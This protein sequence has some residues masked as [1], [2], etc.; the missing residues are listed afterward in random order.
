MSFAKNLARSVVFVASVAA[1]GGTLRGEMKA[2]PSGDV[3]FIDLLAD[4]EQY[5]VTV[6]SD[7]CF[8]STEE[9]LVFQ[10]EGAVVTLEWTDR[11]GQRRRR[12]LT[13]AALEE[14]RRFE[15]GL[16]GAHEG[17][18]TT[19]DTY[20]VRFRGEVVTTKDASCGWNGARALTT[21]LFPG[22]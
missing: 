10:R 2:R 7:G 4:G 11:N 16:S 12:W 1:S 6:Q 5:D 14:I 18:C 21:A 20:T 17:D 19:V 8:H 13:A 22:R 3:R 15:A 9:R